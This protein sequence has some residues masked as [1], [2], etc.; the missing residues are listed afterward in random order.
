MVQTMMN[1]TR[2]RLTIDRD[3]ALLEALRGRD[4]HA[5]ERLVETYGARA[6]RLALR[7]T[8]NGED[9]EEILQDAFLNVTRKIDTFR[10]DSSLG[11]WIYRIVANAA[12]LVPRR[13]ARRGSEITLDDILPVFD[14]DGRHASLVTDWSSSLHDPALQ[15]EL[16]DVLEAA[17]HELPPHY[18]AAIVLRDIEGMSVVETAATL[19]V[20]VAALKTRTHRGRLHLR[21]RL[22][23]YMES[24]G[25]LGL[26]A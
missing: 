9:A 24:A 13:R 18:R 16:R 2:D 20:T 8:G 23:R 19:G 25:A 22:S 5:A 17:L 10:G 21:Q 3:A 7:I 15:R 11:S 12:C 6:Y 1:T 4:P 26:I 14:R